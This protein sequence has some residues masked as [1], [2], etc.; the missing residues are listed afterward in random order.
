MTIKE[1]KSGYK[2][3][4]YGHKVKEEE[5]AKGLEFLKENISSINFAFDDVDEI[6]DLVN[7]TVECDDLASFGF[8]LDNGFKINTMNSSYETV[9]N[10]EH[11][12]YFPS[13]L[14]F[15]RMAYEKGANFS[16]KNKQEMN[17]YYNTLQMRSNLEVFEYLL[18]LPIAKEQLGESY[19]DK[20]NSIMLFHSAIA[21]N[22]EAEAKC[23]LNMGFDINT[24]YT[25]Y[26]RTFITQNALHMACKKGSPE[27]IEFLLKNGIDVNA[28]NSA[29]WAALHILIK[30]G[31][32]DVCKKLEILKNNGADINLKCYF[33]ELINFVDK[34]NGITPLFLALYKKS[35]SCS[36][37]NIYDPLIA[38]L[39]EYGAD[40]SACT[41]NGMAIIHIASEMGSVDVLKKCAE[42]GVDVNQKNNNGETA[43]LRACL[44]NN[45]PDKIAMGLVRMGADKEIANNKGE[46]PI[47]I[48]SKKGKSNLIDFLLE[49]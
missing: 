2:H 34:Y 36:V 35:S 26:D 33:T 5:K 6:V 1:I 37:D 28:V 47:D 29:G 45:N 44:K 38:K 41:D 40:V 32:I 24:S 20:R 25:Y 49:N 18:S 39:L 42:Q 3:F 30:A 17:I 11:F 12:N 10:Q 8:F 13:K 43:L 19:G 14:D 16:K 46:K 48:L 31:D 22:K 7:T 15:V 23:I 27:M 9:F 21:N 4:A